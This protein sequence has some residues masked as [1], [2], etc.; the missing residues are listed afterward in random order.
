MTADIILADG[1]P[2]VTTISAMP[3]LLSNSTGASF[4][5]A[6]GES[7]T[8]ECRLDAGSFAPCAS[9]HVIEGLGDGSHT[10]TVRGTDL[11]GTV[12][13]APP[14]SSWS[15]DTV[16]ADTVLL[17]APPPLTA[18]VD[19]SFSFMAGEAGASF[20]CSLDGSP[21]GG[22]SSPLT[23]TGLAEGPHRFAVRATDPAGNSDPSPAA[24]DWS[25]ARNVLLSRSGEPDSYHVTLGSALATVP[26]GAV[27]SLLARNTELTENLV[28]E[29]CSSVAI[30]GGYAEGFST[31]VGATA[32]TGSVEVRCGTLVVT[33][34]T[35]R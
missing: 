28:M 31:V 16:P 2:P 1:V 14:S 11:T 20:A 10:F 17:A 8:F 13:T 35:I 15:V 33:G 30:R 6:A 32:I 4:S 23:V 25:V 26:S 19:A 3:P 29:S 24:C 18:D 22:C 34:L 27:A 12:E 9:P 7:A 21:W 5:F